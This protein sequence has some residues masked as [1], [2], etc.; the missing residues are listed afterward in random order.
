MAVMSSIAELVP[1]RAFATAIALA[2]RRFEPI[3]GRIGTFVAP[4]QTALDV[5]AWYGPWTHWLS[6]RARCV[7]TVEPNPD[8]A[9]FIAR[10]S[11]PNVTVVTKAASDADGFAELWLPPGGRGTEGRASLIPRP[12]GSSVKIETIRLDTLDLED[13]GLVKIDVEGHELSALKGAEGIVN[14]WRPALIIEV[15]D[16]RSPA[17][18][19]VEL[20]QSW[21]Y[22]GSFLQN[23]KMRPL[24]GFD[25]GAHQR[26]MARVAQRGYLH[27]VA[28]GSG[29]RYV[30]TILFLP[31]R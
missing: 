1:D 10:T 4:H 22:E 5:G 8:L 20:L 31:V 28:T 27:A 12:D 3:L 9:A 19:T 2:H 13:V 21:N 26:A 11:R 18:A 7:T 6:R 16:N 24:A 17:S 15:E 30:N 29:R 14:R 23:G 25:L